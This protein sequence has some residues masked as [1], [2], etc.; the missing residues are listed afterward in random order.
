MIIHVIQCL[1]SNMPTHTQQQDRYRYNTNEKPCLY[2]TLKRYRYIK[3]CLYKSHIGWIIRRAK[4]AIVF[5]N[6]IPCW[7]VQFNGTNQHPGSQCVFCIENVW[8]SDLWRFL[9]NADLKSRIQCELCHVLQPKTMEHVI[10]AVFTCIPVQNTCEN[11]A[12]WTDPKETV[13][14]M[15]YGIQRGN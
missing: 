10:H 5:L 4:G 6:A 12:M 11:D 7:L 2:T 8:I 13:V 14:S 1:C 3:P 9:C 15:L